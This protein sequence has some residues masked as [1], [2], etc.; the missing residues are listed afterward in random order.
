MNVIDL[1]TTEVVVVHPETP[2]KEVARLLIE[3]RISGM[4]VV[5]QDGTVLGVVSEADLLAKEAGVHEAPRPSSLRWLL[6]RD[7]Q[8][9]AQLLRINAVTAGAAMTT[10][11]ATIEAGQPLSAAARRMTEDRINRLPVVKDGRLVGIITRADVVR[12]Y[13]RP[14]DDL[15]ATAQFE[16]RAVDGLRVVSVTDGVATLAGT[17]SHP[18]VAAT[19]RQ[20]VLGIDGMVGVDDRDVGWLEEPEPPLPPGWRNDEPGMGRTT[21]T[22]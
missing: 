9:E 11:A 19:A 16:V 7:R 20:V 4:P 21:R 2:L 15:F 14:D 18:A 10:P 22:T 17:V 5:D 12:A 6:G 3:H 13:A 1:M 8:Q